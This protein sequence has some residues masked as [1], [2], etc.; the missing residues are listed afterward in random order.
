[1]NGGGSRS[2]APVRYGRSVSQAQDEL[3]AVGVL[4]DD[5]VVKTE[6]RGENAM[7]MWRDEERRNGIQILRRAAK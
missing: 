3:V 2:D 5:I 7:V 6:S 1:M 4:F